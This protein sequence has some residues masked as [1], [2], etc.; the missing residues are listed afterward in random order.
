MV[1][2]NTIT[3]TK[4]NMTEAA[5]VAPSSSTSAGST[6]KVEELRKAMNLLQLYNLGGGAPRGMAQPESKEFKFWKTQ[7]VPSLGNVCK[8]HY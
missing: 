1:D 3:N 6:A 2:Q 8:S 5:D 4:P 7:P